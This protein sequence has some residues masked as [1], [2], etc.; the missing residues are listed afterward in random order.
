MRVALDTNILV[1]AEGVNGPERKASALAILRPL[2]G[3]TVLVPVQALG[4]LFAVLVRKA[5]WQAEAASRA[6]RFWA[7]R[8]TPI[9]TT[10]ATLMQAMEIAARHRLAFWDCVVLAAAAE[11]ECETLLTED[12][13]HGFT[14]RGVTLRNPFAG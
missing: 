1:Y 2:E 11:A 9:P 5:R 13:H 6:V 8:S 7:E 3:E 10:E 14:W 12:M 4:E